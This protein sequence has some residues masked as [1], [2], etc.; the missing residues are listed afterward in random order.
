MKP[1]AYI[2]AC[3]SLNLLFG[4]GGDAFEASRPPAIVLPLP[5]A[6][7]DT[8]QPLPDQQGPDQVT[9]GNDA[10][11][12]AMAEVGQD[13]PPDTVTP[14]GG[15][16]GPDVVVPDAGSDSVA[17]E[18]GDAGQGDGAPD[19]DA[20]PDSAPEAGCPF[21]GVVDCLGNQPVIC[22]S[23]KWADNGGLCN[24]GCNLGTCS[25][26]APTG[27]F[28]HYYFEG[29]IGQGRSL[30]NVTGLTWGLAAG[31]TYTVAQGVCQSK[32]FRLPTRVELNAVLG[33]TYPALS[34]MDKDIPTTQDSDPPHT[35]GISEGYWPFK[36]TNLNSVWWTADTIGGSLAYTVSMLDG[37]NMTKPTTES[38]FIMC[39]S[40]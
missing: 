8:I 21:E 9:P 3:L 23:G 24:Y 27:R 37:S 6:A 33:Q 5:D 14:D 40:P 39:V 20:A 19:V 26:G 2:V 18:A 22:Q 4:C 36:A 28:N 13:A 31:G 10:G 30:D 11:S 34:C 16:A 7:G 29:N 1:F 12:D 38:H 32:G 15:D 35:N 17:P 25:C